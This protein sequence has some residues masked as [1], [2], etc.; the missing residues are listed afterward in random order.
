M[1]APD[2]SAA[3]S[4]VPALGRLHDLGVVHGDVS[5]DTVVFSA[6]G[7][8]MLTDVGLS[9]ISGDRFADLGLSVVEMR[10]LFD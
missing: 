10:P 2:T 8:P 9:R 5:P 4:E 1:S 6:D 7:R 3:I